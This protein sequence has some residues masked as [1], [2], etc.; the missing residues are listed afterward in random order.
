[1]AYFGEVPGFP[2]GS[3]FDSRESVRVAELHRHKISG[4]AGKAAEGADAI[5]LNEGYED[6]EDLGDLIIYTGEGG[7]DS[8]KGHQIADQLL[9]KGNAALVNS[10]L[11]GFP[12]RVIRGNKLK[13]PYAPATGYRYDG[14]YSVTSHWTEKGKSGFNIIR[15]KLEK[16]SGEIPP[17]TNKN[18]PIGNR[19]PETKTSVVT[20]T[21]RDSNITRAIK[22][23][24]DDACQ[25]CG[26]QITCEGGTYSEGAHIWPIGKPHHGSDTLDN[27]LCLCPNH[28]AQYDRGG[29]GV[30]DNFSLINIPGSLNV[31][32]EHE[33]DIRN[34]RYHR[35]L[36]P[37]L[38]NK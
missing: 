28:H 2:E 1:M 36:F 37:D 9:I 25:V 22:E 11:H 12:V 34:L 23:L 21:I 29:F 32:P 16:I 4:I 20:R 38:E 6:D 26:I 7:R 27:V 15:F 31:I 13:S 19:N 14:L 5:I 3:E 35:S 33:I 8:N 18:I 24:Y 17:H 10:L 30:A